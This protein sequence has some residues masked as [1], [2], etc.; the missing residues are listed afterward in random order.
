MSFLVKELES[1]E[2]MKGE[3]LLFSGDIILGAPS[4]SIRELQ[5][6]MNSLYLLRKEDFSSICLPHSENLKPESIIVPGKD[7][8]EL[9]I[10]Y[11]EDREK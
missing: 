2:V 8:L 9:Y 4:T 11:R 6:Y 7:K 3:S 10:K 1:Q 5:S